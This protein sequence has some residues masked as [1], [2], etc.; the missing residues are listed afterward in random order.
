[1][2]LTSN[3]KLAGTLTA[4]GTYN[5]TIRAIDLSTGCFVS[6]AYTITVTEPCPAITIEPATLPDGVVGREY[7]ETLT[8]TGGKEPY[9]FSAGGMMPP[10]LELTPE[11]ILKGI[12]T[13]LGSFGIRV[14]ARDDLGCY[15]ARSYT[16]T[17]T[18][19]D[20]KTGGSSR[21]KRG[22]R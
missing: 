1:L 21:D 20:A 10:G 18:K 16:I 3:G 22:N 9:T 6:R 14:T 15:G 13:E 8:A 5:F 7:F 11:G 2:S 17:I 4:L 19:E 12:P